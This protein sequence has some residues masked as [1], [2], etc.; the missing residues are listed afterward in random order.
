L[1]LCVCYA[2]WLKSAH[3][4]LTF[5]DSFLNSTFGQIDGS[6]L[7]ITPLS[8]FSVVIFAFM[9]FCCVLM[10]LMSAFFG[11]GVGFSLARVGFD[12]GAGIGALKNFA[13][14]F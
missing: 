4:L 11:V 8:F 10:I 13:S 3:I 14:D 1:N 5:L 6:I 12:A 2:I 9:S 7:M